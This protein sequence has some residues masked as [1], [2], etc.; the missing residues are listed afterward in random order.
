MSDPTI[1]PAAEARIESDEP[2]VHDSTIRAEPS[3]ASIS[4]PTPSGEPVTEVF[5]APPRASRGLRL[6]ARSVI[7][8]VTVAVVLGVG[9]YFLAVTLSGPGARAG[10]IVPSIPGGTASRLPTAG[11]T[12]GPMPGAP[13]SLRSSLPTAK[14]TASPAP[15]PIQ[16]SAPALVKAWD[17]G[18]GGKALTAVTTQAGDVQMARSTG[19]YSEMMLS[20]EALTSDVQ[21]ALA[22]SAIPDLAM[23]RMYTSA[24]TVL[25]TSAA[26]CSAAIT[27][28]SVG[29]EDTVTHVNQPEITLSMAKLKAGLTDLY[30]A[31]EMMRQQ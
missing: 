3:Q 18:A 2:Q 29:V 22:A 15:R 11:P 4:D 19:D 25:K 6:S 7:I 14:A 1:E 26:D 9:P 5:K 23:Q 20:C 13:L 28:S 21:H 27:Q 24:L 8:I 10:S 31:T 17:A 30:I 16:P 12:G